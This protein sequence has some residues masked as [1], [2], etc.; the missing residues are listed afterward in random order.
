VESVADTET[1][2]EV[3]R[4]GECVADGL[5]DSEPP[6][7][8]LLR[9]GSGELLV[10]SEGEREGLERVDSVTE[11]LALTLGLGV[12]VSFLELPKERVVEGVR[13]PV[14]VTLAVTDPVRV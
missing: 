1:L 7:W 13:V 5:P 2:S 9:V 3:E 12:S 11:T 8:R 6:L 4:E 10:L 14:G